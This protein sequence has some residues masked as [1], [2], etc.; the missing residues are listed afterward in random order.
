M[1]QSMSPKLSSLFQLEYP[2]S[3]GVYN[4]YDDA[5]RVVDFLADQK[6]PVQHLAIVGTELRS[7]ER[8]LGRRN[9]GTVMLAGVQNGVTTGIMISLLMMLFVQEAAAN[10]IVIIVY[11]LLIGIFVG[12]VMSAISYW[13]ARGKR[14]FTSVSQTIATKYEVLAEH[15]VAGQ[16]RGLVATMPG[17][18]AAQFDAGWTAQQPGYGYPQQPGYPQGY[19]QPGYP[20]QAYPQPGFPPAGYPQPYPEQGYPQ[21]TPGYGQPDGTQPVAAAP[22]VPPVTPSAPGSPSSSSEQTPKG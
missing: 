6:F 8:V 7:V 19:P 16:A 11:A 1:T 20:Q 15:K 21:P 3:V 12:V 22:E 4:T 2:Q 13:A 14:D 9:W 10:P 5:Q 18:R 17:A